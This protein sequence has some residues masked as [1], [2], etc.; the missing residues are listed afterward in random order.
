MDC[1]PETAEDVVVGVTDAGA[2]VRG[3]EYALHEAARRERQDETLAAA[4]ERAREKAQR[5]AA[6][7]GLSLGELQRVETGEVGGRSGS[8]MHS[9]VDGALASGPASSVRPDPITVRATVEAVYELE[10]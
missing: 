3:V 5:V 9:I 6:T 7:E 2:S 8:G 10:N 4:T 1:A